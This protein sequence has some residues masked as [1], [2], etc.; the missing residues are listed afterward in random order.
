MSSTVKT[1]DLAQDNIT[2]EFT[3][4]EMTALAALI[5]RGQIGIQ[6]EAG[7]QAGIRHAITGVATEFRSLLG[8]F[9]LAA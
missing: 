5:E 3:E 4:F 7:D 8:H 2:V 9:E 1:I 6:P